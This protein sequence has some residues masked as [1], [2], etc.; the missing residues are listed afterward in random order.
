MNFDSKKW[1]EEKL[2]L[3]NKS[4]NIIYPNKDNEFM[5]HNHEKKGD[6]YMNS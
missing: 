2:F 1:L 5:I 6:Y 4:I 3:Q